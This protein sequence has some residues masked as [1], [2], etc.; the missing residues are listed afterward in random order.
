MGYIGHFS[1]LTALV[2][3]SN[4]ITDTGMANFKKLSSLRSLSFGGDQ[5][6]DGGM[7]HLAGIKDLYF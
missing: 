6:T 2:I 4:R 5:V 7:A 3:E 1:G